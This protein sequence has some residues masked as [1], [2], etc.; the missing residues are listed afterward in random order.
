M[1]TPLNEFRDLPATPHAFTNVARV[2]IHRG[3]YRG[4]SDLHSPTV[5]PVFSFFF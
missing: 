5:I 1:Q 2:L 4:M 3:R